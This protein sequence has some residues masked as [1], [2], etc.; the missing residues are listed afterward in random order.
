[1]ALVIPSG[2]P[3]LIFNFIFVLERFVFL[4]FLALSLIPK[5]LFAAV[6]AIYPPTE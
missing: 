6:R 4:I 5:T 2:V 3:D 1:M